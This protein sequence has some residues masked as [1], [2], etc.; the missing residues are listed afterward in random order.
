MVRFE[1]RTI[2]LLVTWFIALIA[3]LFTMFIAVLSGPLVLA[4]MATPLSA[5]LIA[6][7]G[8]VPLFVAIIASDVSGLPVLV[9]WWALPRFLV[10]LVGL[11]TGPVAVVAHLLSV[12]SAASSASSAIFASS[13]LEIAS[14]LAPFVLFSVTPPLF[15]LFRTLFRYVAR[16]V[17]IVAHFLAPSLMRASSLLVSSWFPLSLNMFLRTLSR[18]VSW[19]IAIIAH[20]IA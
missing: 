8:P 13:L 16:I 12:V 4:F 14:S 15:A 2:S 3:K 9:S 7:V 1:F 6:I 17:A 5:L 19:L 10:T 20:S 18:N 11:V